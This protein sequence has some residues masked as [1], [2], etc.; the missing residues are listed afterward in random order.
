VLALGYFSDAAAR[1]GSAQTCEE[2]AAKLAPMRSPS[3]IRPSD[4]FVTPATL[5][6][7]RRVPNP[8]VVTAVFDELALI[9]TDDPHRALQ[10]LMDC[11]LRLYGA[12]S[13]GLSVLRPSSYGHAD[14]VW[15]VVSGALA[16]H[17][18]DGTPGEFSPCGLC[19]DVGTAV[20]LARPEQA[21]TY[22]ARVHPTIV[23]A[24]I[25]PLYNDDGKA[26]G[27]LW[28]AHH[29][30]AARFSANDVLIIERLAAPT[31]E[32]LLRVQAVH[33]ATLDDES[34]TAESAQ[35]TAGRHA[36]HRTSDPARAN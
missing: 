35:P 18:G 13:A 22:L 9:L 4:L 5:R 2:L 34:R 21:F 31:A 24:L 17:R 33:A 23:E 12:G 36:T 3:T 7:R 32:A 16:A 19:L 27:A 11:V 8:H 25:V 1:Y 30:P 29:D 15:E 6:G 28:V 14:F 20:V 26:L 10:R